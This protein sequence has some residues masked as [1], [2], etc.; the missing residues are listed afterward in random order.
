MLF[1]YTRMKPA[2]GGSKN[3]LYFAGVFN[4]VAALILVV[5]ARLAPDVI[6]LDPVTRSQM[7]FVDLSAWL[8]VGFGIGYVLGGFD[9]A[10][11]WP[12]IALG[13]VGKAGVVLLVTPYFLLGATGPLIALLVVGDGIF[14][15]LFV[16]LLRAHAA[17]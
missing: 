5:L 12:F 13:A 3:F 16:R 2:I 8:V 11:F 14:A 1:N 6:G 4:F 10:R 9:L 7:L 15:F 17:H